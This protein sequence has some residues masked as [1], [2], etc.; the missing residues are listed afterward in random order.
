MCVSP[1]ID[2]ATTDIYM[3]E[4]KRLHPEF[5]VGWQI[6]MINTKL[7]DFE[8]SPGDI[9]NIARK[10]KIQNGFF[11][12]YAIE[13]AIRK[14]LIKCRA[15]ENYIFVRLTKHGEKPVLLTL[16]TLSIKPAL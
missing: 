7:D 13:E 14:V 8:A 3:E 16:E 15:P 11:F 5:A 2:P 1:N 10:L 12:E 9:L 6:E 4:V